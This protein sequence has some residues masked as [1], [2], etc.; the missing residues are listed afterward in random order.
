MMIGGVLYTFG[1]SR[2]AT[3]VIALISVMVSGC[4]RNGG[5]IV[6]GKVTLDGQP[7]S[8][9]QV[10]FEPKGPGRMSVAQ[11]N[12]G[13]YSLPAGF[14]IQPGEYVVRITSERPTGEKF[15]PAVYS[16]DKMVMDV[17]EQF[18]PA[19]YNSQ[20]ALTATVSADGDPN[21]DFALSS[22]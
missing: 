5:Y 10:V 11:I 8:T 21:H 1:C 6:S 19:K 17:Y 20:S 13:S 12:E 9:G 14:G 16:Q 3:L 2:W 7:L 18:L 15:K 22:K 4:G